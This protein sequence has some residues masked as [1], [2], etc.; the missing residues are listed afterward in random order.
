MNAEENLRLLVNAYGLGFD[1]PLPCPVHADNDHHALYEAR[2][3]AYCSDPASVGGQEPRGALY[4]CTCNSS[5]P[6]TDPAHPTSP[7]MPG[8]R[9]WCD[10]CSREH[11]GVTERCGNIDF[12]RELAGRWLFASTSD[13]RGVL[14]DTEV[15]SLLRWVRCEMFGETERR[16]CALLPAY[17]N[18]TATAQHDGVDVADPDALTHHIAQLLGKPFTEDDELARKL[19]EVAAER[20]G[21]WP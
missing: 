8:P 15:T 4:R 16:A 9:P 2:W 10:V 20:H 17:Q 3:R 1:S 12:V 7:G 6:C 19:C 11:V 18:G 21:G 5:A 14:K 13:G